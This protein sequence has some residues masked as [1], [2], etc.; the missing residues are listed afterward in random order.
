MGIDTYKIQVTGGL[1]IQTN[2]YEYFALTAAQLVN[3]AT[4]SAT[5]GQVQLVEIVG[6]GSYG[7]F[8]L[9]R[10]GT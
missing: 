4:A 7:I 5:I 6:N 10:Q 1:L 8:K 9:T 3:F 2:I